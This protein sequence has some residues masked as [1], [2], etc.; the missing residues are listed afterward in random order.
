MYLS[1][2]SSY[3]SA[4]DPRVFGN[5]ET[6]VQDAS[7]GR[8]YTPQDYGRLLLDAGLPWAKPIADYYIGFL[9]MS[10]RS[11]FPLVDVYAEKGSG[12][13]TV[14]GL[15]LPDLTVGQPLDPAAPARHARR[16]RQPG[17]HHQRRRRRLGGMPCFHFS[18]TDNP[19]VDHFSLPSDRR[20]SPG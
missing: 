6:V 4:A 13:D 14:V 15:G 19:G 20:C 8:S 7:T 2:P 3:I 16:R 1:A 5:R 12:I 11:S 10:D 9:D 17:G 18:L